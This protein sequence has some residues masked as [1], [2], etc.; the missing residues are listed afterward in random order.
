MSSRMPRALPAIE[1]GR[2]PY[3]RRGVARD[4]HDYDRRGRR[5]G[6]ANGEQQAEA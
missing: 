4:R 1:L 2:L 6:A 3:R 5:H